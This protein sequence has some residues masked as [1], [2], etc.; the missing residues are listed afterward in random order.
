MKLSDLITEDLIIPSLNGNDVST[1][2]REFA[3]AICAS[4]KYNDEELLYL[5]LLERENQE[6]TGIGNG[7]AIPHCK[8]DN[9][10]QVVLSIGYS[11]NGV[12]FKAI[13]GKP[14][15]FFFVVISSSSASVLHLRTLAAL[16]RLLKSPAFIA[17]LQL[18]P[19]KHELMELIRRQEENA[20]VIP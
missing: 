20:A 16:S 3:A 2:L 14:T 1:V 9:L 8:V 19:E 18:R 6:S 13:D 11:K 12:D 10:Q 4:G 5:R 15:Y 17:Q 7:V